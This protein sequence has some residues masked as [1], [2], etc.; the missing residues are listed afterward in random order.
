MQ[1]ANREPHNSGEM[2]AL[3]QHQS[4]AG[5]RCARHMVFLV[6]VAV[7]RSR[8]AT[9][10]TARNSKR[11]CVLLPYKHARHRT[12]YYLLLGCAHDHG[13]IAVR[14]QFHRYQR[15]EKEYSVQ[16]CLLHKPRTRRQ[17]PQDVEV[18]GQLAGANG[19]DCRIRSRR[20]SLHHSL[21]RAARSGHLLLKR[22]E[23]AWP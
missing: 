17:R 4:P 21:S 12:R 14:T 23:R 20:C 6:A 16:G 13:R 18:A 2:P 11:S 5:R 15:S 1:T 10:G 8:L 7:L 22:K 3:R 19:F 9:T